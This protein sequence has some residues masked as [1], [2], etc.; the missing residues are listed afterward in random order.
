MLPPADSVWRRGSN[1]SRGMMRLVD[2]MGW[3]KSWMPVAMGSMHSG[4]SNEHVAEVFGGTKLPFEG[5][6][7][8]N[9]DVAVAL[10]VDMVLYPYQTPL[11]ADLRP[12]M[13]RATAYKHDGARVRLLQRSET[14]GGALVQSTATLAVMTL[15]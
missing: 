2:W 9:S 7:R 4:R 3:V 11:S 5:N 8:Y 14:A 6:T 15:R 12:A 1:G 13:F 10:D